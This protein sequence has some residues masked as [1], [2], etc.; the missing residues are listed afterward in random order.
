MTIIS[1]TMKCR[2]RG[3]PEASYEFRTMTHAESIW[4]VT[5]PSSPWCKC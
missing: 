1:E 3:H 5:T 2:Q 4:R